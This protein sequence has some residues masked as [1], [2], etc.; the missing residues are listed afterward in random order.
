MCIKGHYQENENKKPTES[1]NIFANHIFD[2]D[3][4]SRITLSTQRQKTQLKMRK[5]FNRHMKRCQHHYL[6]RKHK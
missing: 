2:K 1:E 5:D 3:L 4:M 6:S